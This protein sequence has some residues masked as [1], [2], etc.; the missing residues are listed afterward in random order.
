MAEMKDM[1]KLARYID[2]DEY[3][4]PMRAVLNGLDAINDCAKRYALKSKVSRNKASKV[5]EAAIE[6]KYV[7]VLG[8][9][10]SGIVLDVT[11][12]KGR[13]FIAKKWFIY[14]SG[15]IDDSLK[16]YGRS[17]RFYAGTVVGGVI[18]TVLGVLVRVI[19]T[20]IMHW[21]NR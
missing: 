18:V 14:P 20:I 12:I 11:P 9:D 3:D 8:D 7:R 19:W 5:I 1:Y 10:S 6:H 2:S 15:L 17:Q 21:F 16:A 4:T 13:H